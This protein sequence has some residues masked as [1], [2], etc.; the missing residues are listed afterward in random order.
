MDTLM[1]EVTGAPGSGRAETLAPGGSA[2]S[3]ETNLAR[4]MQDSH[5]LVVCL[6]TGTAMQRSEPGGGR[7]RWPRDRAE[8]SSNG[9]DVGVGG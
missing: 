1:D 9:A 7:R 3:T 6:D 5:I 4:S 2:G 8:K